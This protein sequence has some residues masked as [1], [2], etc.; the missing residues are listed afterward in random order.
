MSKDLELAAQQSYLA[1]IDRCEALIETFING[2]GAGN[3]DTHQNQLIEE[4]FA[5][6]A[7]PAPMNP[8]EFSKESVMFVQYLTEVR[9]DLTATVGPVFDMGRKAESV[10]GTTEDSLLPGPAP[11]EKE[12]ESSSDKKKKNSDLKTLWYQFCIDFNDQIA[13]KGD[14]A[15]KSKKIPTSF[16]AVRDV[17]E[18]VPT[19]KGNIPRNNV[20]DIWTLRKRATE[21]PKAEG[22][23][24]RTTH[25]DW[26]LTGL[27][28]KEQML[29]E[30][31]L[32]QSNQLAGD[33]HLENFLLNAG[34]GGA[35]Q[36]HHHHHAHHHHHH[37]HHHH[38]HH[39]HHRHHHQHHRM[40]GQQ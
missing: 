19:S 28:P 8:T 31:L 39:H 16:Y 6:D 38:H 12:D 18:S 9:T 17:R 7:T 20:N 4:L 36:H 13:I 2:G 15:D 25:Y 29:G 33:V 23:G 10:A 1:A 40:Q 22:G 37:R 14:D 5:T 24:A 3:N 11:T 32:E 34:G 35:R 27:D 21:W 26:N 30:Q